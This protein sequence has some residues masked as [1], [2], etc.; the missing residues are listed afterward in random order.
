MFI[1][2]GPVK[3]TDYSDGRCFGPFP[4]YEA[5][6]DW[7]AKYWSLFAIFPVEEAKN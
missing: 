3:G 7:A 1:V 4:N 5:A 2:I 6:Y